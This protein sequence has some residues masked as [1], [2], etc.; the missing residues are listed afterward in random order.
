[1]LYLGIQVRPIEELAFE[2]EFRGSEYEGSSYY[3]MI[4]RVK[5][6]FTGP[7]FISAGYRLEE[8]EIDDVGI[9]AD[10]EFSGPFAEAGFQF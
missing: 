6:N 9:L 4:G 3:D 7:V 2:V 8:L 1:M 10:L 5:Y